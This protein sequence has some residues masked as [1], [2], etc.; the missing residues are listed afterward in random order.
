MYA[1]TLQA[2]QESTTYHLIVGSFKTF[3]Q[4][5]QHI[6][7]LAAEGIEAVTLF[8]NSQT[9][10]YRVS[11]Y[12]SKNRDEV[13]AFQANLKRLGKEAGWIYAEK[14]LPPPAK[15]QAPAA[16]AAAEIQ[17]TARSLTAASASKSSPPATTSN[18]EIDP[19]I[20]Y[21]LIAGS[22]P[23]F[24]TANNHAAELQADGFE[25]LILLPDEESDK[26][27]V[28]VY[29]THDK[30]EID[31]YASYLRRGGKVK[32]WILARHGAAPANELAAP[33]GELTRSIPSGQ[34]YYLIRGSF[35]NRTSAEQFMAEMRQAGY[36]TYLLQPT[37]NSRNRYRVAIYRAPN[38]AEVEA[39]QKTLKSQGKEAGWILQQ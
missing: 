30:R 28:S 10:L 17:T 26:Y 1:H 36:Q 5:D 29:F 34:Q 22:H 31:A 38:R 16:A 12:H 4:A 37:P 19:N 33:R 39:F 35:K 7:K 20:T 3:E 25:T 24:E 11:V 13:K 27:R 2:Q 21:Y 8:P 23:D 6:R 32:G 9:K 18:P 14:P 15:T